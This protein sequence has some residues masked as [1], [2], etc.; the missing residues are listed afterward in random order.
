MTVFGIN[1]RLF[2]LMVETATFERAGRSHPPEEA[3]SANQKL[4]PGLS[5]LRSLAGGIKFT[6]ELRG[7]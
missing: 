2:F 6:F 3:G 1:K 7:L 5:A 4:L